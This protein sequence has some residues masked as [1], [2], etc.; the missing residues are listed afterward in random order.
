MGQDS[1]HR[2]IEG[3]PDDHGP[4]I[5]RDAMRAYGADW[6]GT[7]PDLTPT[8]EEVIDAGLGRVIAVPNV[9]ATARGI[10]VPV[11][12]R[13]STMHTIRDGKVVRGREYMTMGEALRAAGLSCWTSASSKKASRH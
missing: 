10:S 3:T 7:F 2:A 1:D 9:T 8:L 5:G 12:I 4:I 13:A 6:Y 11:K